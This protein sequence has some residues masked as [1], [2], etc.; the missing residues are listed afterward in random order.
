[1]LDRRSLLKYGAVAGSALLAPSAVV[2]AARAASAPAAA[3]SGAAPSAAPQGH[4]HA[5]GAAAVPVDA[6]GITAT[7]FSVPL[8]IPR[9][10]RPTHRSRDADH[11]TLTHAPAEEEIFLGT[12]T[13]IYAYGGSFVGPTIRARRGR[14]VTITHHNG[15]ADPTTVHLH[16]GHVPADSDGYPMDLIAPGASKTYRYPNSQPSATLWYHDHAHGLEAEHVYR[17]LHGFYLLEDPAEWRLRLPGGRYDIPLLL[18]DAQFDADGQLVWR[19]NDFINRRTVL[20]NGRPQPYLRVAARRYRLRLLDAANL[21]S[22]ALSL[23]TGDPLVQVASDGGLLPAPASVPAVSISPGER[24]EV[25]VD[26]SR[27]APG[28]QVFLVD[29]VAGQ[30]LRFDVVDHAFDLS[31]VPAQL[32][33]MPGLPTPTTTRQVSLGMD[34]PTGTFRINGKL[35]DMDRVDAVIQRGTSEVWE[36]TNTD[37]MLGIPHNLHLHLVQFRVLTRNGQPPAPT[38]AGFKDTVPVAPGEV[39]RVLATFGDY[40]GRYVY[41]C[42]LLDHS[43]TGMM[44]QFEV[45]A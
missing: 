37:T 30:L 10:L 42:H 19:M 33:Q 25:V 3:G 32:R 26:F 43:A 7:P 24:A 38:E 9:T 17:G 18:N 20:V 22:F 12:R 28:T 6:P 36:I 31:R 40:V 11:Y 15:L 1:M 44:A 27:Y 41:H 39:V 2:T 5:H 21:R 14:A 8:P 45:V 29:A 16:G 35:F 13:A 23:S 4:V 34:L